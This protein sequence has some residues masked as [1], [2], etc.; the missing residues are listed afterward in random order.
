MNNVK[1]V[2]IDFVIIPHEKQIYISEENTSGCKYQY[3]S[4]HDISKVL[5]K[6]L[7]LYHNEI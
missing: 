6:Y 7:S 4:K 3:K 1:E 5:E 2:Q